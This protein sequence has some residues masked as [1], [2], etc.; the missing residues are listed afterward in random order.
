MIYCM[1]K[2]GNIVNQD[3][4]GIDRPDLVEKIYNEL[5]EWLCK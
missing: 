3:L 1:N 4:A 2:N 5:D